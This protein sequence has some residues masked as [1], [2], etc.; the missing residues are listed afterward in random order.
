MLLGLL[1]QIINKSGKITDIFS[2]VDKRVQSKPSSVLGHIST[3]L[4]CFNIGCAQ[5]T[6][7]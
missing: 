4:L 6:C 1:V 7:R 5:K 2:R 3:L